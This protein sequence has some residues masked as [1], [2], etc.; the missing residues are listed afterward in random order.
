MFN[1]S[2][3][4]AC[5]VLLLSQF[6]M[7]EEGESIQ[8]GTSLSGSKYQKVLK[9]PSGHDLLTEQSDAF[10][11]KMH[12]SLRRDFLRHAICLSSIM[13]TVTFC[14]AGASAKRVKPNKRLGGLPN[15]IYDVCRIL[16]ELQRDLM[17]ERWDLVENYPARLRSYVPVFTAYTDA[18]F[19]SD[20]PSDKSYRV[21]LRYE[22]G[23]MFSSLGRLSKAVEKRALDDSYVNYSD[24]SVHFDRYLRAGNLYT[25]EQPIK[26]TEALY[27]DVKESQLI[28]SDPK[29][30]AAEVRDLIVLC[31]GP[32]KG[33][34]GIVIGIYRDGSDT[35][36]VKLDKLR[37][38]YDIREIRV[39]PRLWAAKRIGEQDP[40]EV[41]LI[42]RKVRKKPEVT[43]T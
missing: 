10:G 26:S 40:D 5:I 4:Q 29:K 28:Y 22:V 36:A 20:A 21:E 27:N 15:R 31:R 2:R 7:V 35:C 11:D 17:Q 42:P 8:M 33:K 13:S 25:Y 3:A 38:Y 30:D 37:S 6:F 16:D 1:L 23:R 9:I 32:D 34:T 14:P 39:V 43:N 18:A 41:F 19:P 12:A 24:V